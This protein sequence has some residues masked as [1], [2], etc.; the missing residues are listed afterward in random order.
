VPGDPSTGGGAATWVVLPIDPVSGR[1]AEPVSLGPA[2]LEGRLPPRCR[3][4]QDGWLVDG[5]LGTSVVLSSSEGRSYLDS[6]EFR[7]RLGPGTRCVEAIAAR[8]G[9]AL[10][11]SDDGGSGSRRLRS[12]SDPSDHGVPLA[13]RAQSSASRWKLWCEP[14]EPSS[15]S[16]VEQLLRAP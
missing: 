10:R 6:I 5:P 7:L 4:D 11:S 9:R 2:D 16:R 12:A 13:V 1:M 8:T 3:A 14:S 15:P